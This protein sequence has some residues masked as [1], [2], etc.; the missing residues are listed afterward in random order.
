MAKLNSKKEQEKVK[1][2]FDNPRQILKVT[3]KNCYPNWTDLEVNHVVNSL[4]KKFY[5][6]LYL[7]SSALIEIVNIGFE[8]LL[9]KNKATIINPGYWMNRGFKEGLL[10]EYRSKIVKD[11]NNLVK[12]ESFID[13]IYDK[14]KDENE[15]YKNIILYAEEIEKRSSLSESESELFEL[16][17]TL[18]LECTATGSLNKTLKES[19]LALG[20]KDVNYRTLLKLLRA[21][22]N[23]PLN[24]KSKEKHLISFVN[25]EQ[26]NLE[27]TLKAFLNFI[28]TQLTM[29]NHLQAYRF[30]EQEI[31]KMIELKGIFE[32]N[33]FKIDRFPEVYYD[34]YDNYEE[35][36]GKIKDLDENIDYLGVYTDFWIPSDEINSKEG[37]IVLFKDRIE[38]Y[39]YEKQIEVNSVRFIVLM[40]ELG[41]WL[42][43]WAT[44]NNE[45]WSKG[46]KAGTDKKTHESLAQLIAY[47][48]V[49]DNSNLKNLLET[50]LTPSKVDD[51]YALYKNLTKIDETIIL[52][53]IVEI[54][55]HAF[56]TDDLMY[57]FLSSDSEFMYE[58]FINNIEIKGWYCIN[59]L[60]EINKPNECFDDAVFD[61]LVNINKERKTTSCSDFPIC[62]LGEYKFKE[63]FKN[64]FSQIF[65][66]CRGAISG[67]KFGI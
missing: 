65:I 4:Y 12:N 1:P 9:L 16:L 17:I 39:C 48:A 35:I 56:L 5:T 31:N 41:H 33:E 20:Y 58:I 27:T 67:C 40:H 37:I 30:S 57:A 21:K 14:A 46:Y 25:T 38:K 44:Y 26:D 11:D 22:L 64:E 47:W 66:D 2:I 24:I 54:R 18:A 29:K 32:Q 49:K 45:N 51:P 53:K 60:N 7:D 13:I 3:F 63:K 34:D 6:C 36:Y 55:K 19:A 62:L 8:K 52:K 15:I 43:H 50:H 28:E 10:E 23:S 42:T 61:L 59:L